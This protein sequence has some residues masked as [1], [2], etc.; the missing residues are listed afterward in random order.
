MLADRKRNFIACYI[1]GGV[2]FDYACGDD[3][4]RLPND[5]CLSPHFCSPFGEQMCLKMNGIP[6]FFLPR[7]ELRPSGKTK[8][9]LSTSAVTPRDSHIETLS[10]I[11][12]VG[13]TSRAWYINQQ[14]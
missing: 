11:L 7:R 8:W 14:D 13:N 1:K 9:G 6:D 3:E 12:G 5:A 10:L 2:G 4:H